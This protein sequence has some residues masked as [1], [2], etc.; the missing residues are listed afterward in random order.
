MTHTRHHKPHQSALP[1]SNPSRELTL[2]T[3]MQRERQQ[4]RSE[5]PSRSK[6][7]TR[8]LELC[9]GAQAAMLADTGMLHS[10]CALMCWH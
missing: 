7:R 3:H 10:R 6:K 8:H 5:Q 9:D 2:T 4:A 1:V